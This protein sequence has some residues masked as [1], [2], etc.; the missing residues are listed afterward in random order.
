[1]KTFFLPLAI[2][3]LA[4]TTGFSQ[5]EQATDSKTHADHAQNTDRVEST[6]VKDKHKNHDASDAAAMIE[7]SMA[8]DDSVL[9]ET[10]RTA[11]RHLPT[12]SHRRSRLL[13]AA[14]Q[15]TSDATTTESSTAGRAELVEIV[16]DMKF[17]PIMEADQPAGF[18]G[19]YS[20]G[21]DR[22]EVVPGIPNGKNFD[23]R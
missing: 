18:S 10:V 20:C 7:K 5:E 23:Q 17:Q 16:D 12:D 14:D 21:R 3:L 1:M 19:D 6:S 11:A 4:S 9:A 15:L 13:A 2:V 8:D 22:T